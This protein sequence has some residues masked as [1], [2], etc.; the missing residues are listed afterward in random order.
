MG[1]ATDGI[2][3]DWEEAINSGIAGAEGSKICGF[4]DL[5]DSGQPLAL[6]EINFDDYVKIGDLILILL[7]PFQIILDTKNGMLVSFLLV[8]KEEICFGWTHGS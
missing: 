6:Q 5:D 3:A 7:I 2:Y 1:C 4:V 8:K